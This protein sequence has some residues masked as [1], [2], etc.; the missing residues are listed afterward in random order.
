MRSNMSVISS[1]KSSI[2]PSTSVP[3]FS[4]ELS[5]VANLVQQELQTFF[6][7]RLKYAKTLDSIHFNTVTALQEM[8]LRGGKRIRPYLC[9]CGYKLAGGTEDKKIVRVGAAV[10]LLHNYLMN[11]DDMADRDTVRHGGPTLEVVYA[12]SLFA[13][14]PKDT[15]EHYARTWS[16]IAGAILNTYIYELIRTSGFSSDQIVESLEIIN[17]HMLEKTAVGWQIH[18]MQ[19]HEPLS[20]VKEERF[21]KGLRLVTAQYTFVS[22]LLLGVIFAGKRS[23]FESVLT[24][25]GTHVGT[26]FQIQDD[27]LGLFG[28]AEETGKAVGNDVREGKKTLLI[29][30]AYRHCNKEDQTFLEKIVG[31][32]ITEQELERVQAIVRKSGSLQYS[33]DK[34]KKHVEDGVSAIQSLQTGDALMKQHL[35]EVA[36]FVM[37]RKA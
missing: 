1:T 14:Y 32:A 7:E 25:Y 26:A 13:H 19:N 11:L 16:E 23:V 9:W 22:P 15:R 3:H 35:I 37:Q 29:Q 5:R 36:Q 6:Q 8:V 12:K 4:Q 21:E 2:N 31:S 33:Q 20:Q 27:I 34:A 30:Y 17:K 10:E 24:T 28:Q 18:M